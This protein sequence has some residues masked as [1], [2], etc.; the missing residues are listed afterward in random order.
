MNICLIGDF[1]DYP[2]EGF[3]N[4]AYFYYKKLSEFHN[5]TPLNI[6]S[7]FSLVFLNGIKRQH[8]PTI[9]HYLTDPSP[10]SLILLKLLKLYWKNPFTVV[11][12]LH[13]SYSL[14]LKGSI[15]FFKPDLVLVQSNKS[16]MFFSKNGCR[17]KFLMNGVDTIRFKPANS[18]R[19]KQ[20]RNQY[21]IPKDKI[22]LLHVGHLKKNRNVALFTK[23][24][25]ERFYNLIVGSEY[26]QV[27]HD[28]IEQL[29]QARCKVKIGFIE[30][31]Q[32]YYALSDCYI[33]PVL[34][35][36]SILIPLSVLEAMSCNL[37]VISKPFEGLSKMFSEENGL[38]YAKTDEDFIRIIEQFDPTIPVKT[39]DMVLP[40]DWDSII[41]QL[42]G[43][44]V[45]ILSAKAGE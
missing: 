1:N 32:D 37:A 18:E 42:N 33:F 12:A 44:Y 27:D 5:V 11:T 8:K 29:E 20:L 34:E 7:L 16:H 9:I 30:N 10:L 2:D 4:I 3:K 19:K 21:G 41:S 25:N 14:A 15:R 39:R 24:K 23:I 31:I 6:K 13:P 35:Y 26:I 36:H 43:I 22:V 40:Y 28:I 17:T 38:I 45:K